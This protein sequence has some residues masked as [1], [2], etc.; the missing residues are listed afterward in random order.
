MNNN[1]L[2]CVISSLTKCNHATEIH[3]DAT[4]HET[5]T[6]PPGLLSLAIKVLERN[7]SNATRNY[8]ATVKLHH[9]EPYAT[10]KFADTELHVEATNKTFITS[11]QNQESCAVAFPI[12]SNYA[13]G[14]NCSQCGYHKSACECAHMRSSERVSC[15]DCEYFSPDNLDNVTGIGTCELGIIWTQEY[16]G[17]K[18]LYRYAKRHCGRFS[19]L[20]S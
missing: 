15:N 7:K 19:K 2:S 20:I 4:H 16:N 10:K 6:Q 12:E 14:L 9:T 5:T 13:T 18:P 3:D 17:Q 11:S 8:S 1:S